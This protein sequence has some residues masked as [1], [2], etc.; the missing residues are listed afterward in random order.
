MDKH[1]RPHKCTVS[2][3]KVT[4]FTNS[5][6][7]KRHQRTVHGT[8]IFFCPVPSCKRHTRGFG[9]KDNREEHVKRVHS[10][11]TTMNSRTPER[12]DSGDQSSQSELVGGGSSMF[13]GGDSEMEV[14]PA[15][16]A[17]F[18]TS[19]FSLAAKLEELRDAKSAAI[20]EVAA[21]YD[22]DIDAVERV[23]SLT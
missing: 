19:K 9:R 13:E 17:S 4:D 3:C 15:E 2:N 16:K 18:A 5:G 8:G 1:E 14:L 20:A 23:L 12:Q 10:I 6:D 21:K 11:E 7:L 22:K